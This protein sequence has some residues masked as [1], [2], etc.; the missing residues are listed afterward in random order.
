MMNDV[1]ILGAIEII[2]WILA[3]S[4]ELLLIL[5]ILLLL[6]PLL[7]LDRNALVLL[8]IPSRL[9]VFGAALALTLVRIVAI[10]S[11]RA[12]FLASKTA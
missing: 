2:V 5:L 7:F 6:A 4:S 9:L 12:L 8:L 3:I 10:K 11:H 1:T